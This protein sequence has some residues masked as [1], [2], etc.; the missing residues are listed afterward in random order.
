MQTSNWRAAPRPL[1][2]SGC[3]G[4]GP[5]SPQTHG[6]PPTNLTPF[7]PS[8]PGEDP[9]LISKQ[10]IFA[11]I[12]SALGGRATEE[13]VWGSAEVTT[14]ASSDLQQVSNMAR[15]M[16][17]NYGFSEIGPYSLQDQAAQS[18]DM[19]MRMMAKNSISESLQQ[20]IDAAVKDIAARA[21]EEALRHIRDN[22]AAMDKVVEVLLER[23]TMSGDE[24]RA[25]LAEYA[26]IPDENLEAVRQQKAQPEPVLS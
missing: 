14:G 9:T 12:V 19:I 8:L 17:I 13:V 15:S 24:F 1:S 2:S 25:I 23:E 11:R 7:L 22:R 21:Y 6:L 16:V 18:P 3:L 4:P 26:E 20:R 5:A 10:Q